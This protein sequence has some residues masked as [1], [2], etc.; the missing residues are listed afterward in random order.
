M[1]CLV[2]SLHLARLLWVCVRS[3]VSFLR[4][5]F[6]FSGG[7]SCSLE[8]RRGCSS[9]GSQV[10]LFRAWETALH[11]EIWLDSFQFGI[12]SDHSSSS[13]LDELR[14]FCVVLAPGS[15]WSQVVEVVLGESLT[16]SVSSLDLSFTSRFL[17]TFSLGGGEVINPLFLVCGDLEASRRS[18]ETSYSGDDLGSPGIRGNEENLTF[19]RSLSMVANGNRFLRISK[20]GLVERAGLSGWAKLEYKYLM[21]SSPHPSRNIHL[22]TGGGIGWL[23]LTLKKPLC[24]RSMRRKAACIE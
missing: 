1:S 8:V 9:G 19:P 4:A 14:G 20:I 7:S 16:A 15:Q 13:L 23:D 11:L 10:G 5:R 24:R 18:S 3:P 17:E 22:Q 6:V 12:K 21:D 2:R